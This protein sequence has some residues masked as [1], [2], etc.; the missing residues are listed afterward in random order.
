MS[1]K[2][3]PLESAHWKLRAA[4]VNLISA[5]KELV[6]FGKSHFHPRPAE[7]DEQNRMLVRIGDF[8]Y[9]WDLSIFIGFI[10]HSLRATLD[11]LM[12]AIIAPKTKDAIQNTQFP[13]Y[14]KGKRQFFSNVGRR[15]CGASK[16]LIRD[17][18]A[19]Q[20]YHRRKN[21]NSKY[22]GYIAD[23]DNW[24]KHRR[25]PITM[26]AVLAS[27]V[28]A[29]ILNSDR[30]TIA[31]TELVRGPLK[32][33]A[34]IAKISFSGLQVNDQV[35][36]DANFTAMPIFGNGMPK[37]LRGL[38]A[39]DTLRQAGKLIHSEIFPMMRRHI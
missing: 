19:L 6:R 24:D 17:I 22:L 31:E 32:P 12:F 4:E 9:P 34:V 18:E 8:P 27:S 38:H 29:V 37:H 14:T 16:A 23:I 5:D 11:H 13:I 25:L 28:S 21:P 35:K 30:S 1:G 36:V 2:P 39:L 26:F 3:D 33:H 7:R 20:P 10:A 15:M